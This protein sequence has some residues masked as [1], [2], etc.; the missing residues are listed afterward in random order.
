[1]LYYGLI[2]IY[3]S[4]PFVVMKILPKVQNLDIDSL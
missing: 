2:H 1:M 4:V 3:S